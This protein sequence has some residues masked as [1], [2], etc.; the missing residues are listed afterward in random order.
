MRLGRFIIIVLDSFGIGAMAD[1]PDVRPQDRGANTYRSVLSAVPDVAFPNLEGLGLANAAGFE[2]GGVRFS[3]D[4]VFGRSDLMHFWCDSY[5]GHQELVGTLPRK[6]MEAPFSSM[7][8]SVASALRNAGHSVDFYGGG[9]KVLVVDHAMVI[10]DNIEADFGQ[11]YNVTASFDAA[12]FEE[13][14]AVGRIVRKLTRVARVITFGSPGVSIRR[15]LGALETRNA[16][17]VGINAPRSGV[18]RDGYLVAHMGFGVDARL[19]LPRVLKNCGRKVVLIGKAAD[20]IDNEGGKSISAV[21]TETVMR[22]TIAEIADLDVGFVCANVQ[23]TDLA[24]HREDAFQYAEKL[25]IA[26]RFIGEIMQLLHDEDILVV[27]ADHGNDPL[28]GHPQ[29]TR[30]RVPMLFHYRAPAPGPP[31]HRDEKNPGRHGRD[32]GPLLLGRAAFVRGKLP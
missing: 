24:G 15:I 3:R 4:A 27:T 2:A 18:Y 16:A 31:R 22:T 14:K 25:R 26:D 12:P 1:V 8:D 28:I 5:W 21:D 23:E 17:Y 11:N 20:I 32:R 13:V 29:H 30:E 6:P 7:I 10:G 19:Q 9:L